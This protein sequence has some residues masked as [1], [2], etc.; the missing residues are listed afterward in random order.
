MDNQNTIQKNLEI[1]QN[2][3]GDNETSTPTPAPKSKKWLWIGLIGAAFTVILVGVILIAVFYNQEVDIVGV[4]ESTSL[5]FVKDDRYS[6][7]LNVF[8]NLNDDM[9]ED[10]LREMIKQSGIDENYLRVDADAGIGYIST[11]IINE[12]EEYLGQNVEYISF[13][14]EPAEDETEL[15]TI[16]NITYHNYHDGTYDVI[17]QTAVYEYTH[18]YDGYSNSFDNVIDAIDDYLMRW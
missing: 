7:L 14:Y 4:G 10:D 8:A 1:L 5:V 17:R 12:D 15:N 9:I 18:E 13:D 2:I 16:D 11:A 3:S 6:D